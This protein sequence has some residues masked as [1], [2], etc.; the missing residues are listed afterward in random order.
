MRRYLTCFL[1][2]APCLFATAPYHGWCEQGGA[3]VLTQGLNSSTLVQQSFPNFSQSG[4]GPSVTV[5]FTG[6]TNKASLSSDSMGTVL[7]N[8]FPCSATGEYQFWA[9]TAAYDIVISG[10]G[11]LTYTISTSVTDGCP[12]NSACDANFSSLATACA[13]VG[14]GTL[15]VTFTWPSLPTGSY[16]CVMDFLSKNGTIQP[17]SGQTVTLNNCPIAGPYT[18]FDI[19]AGGTVVVPTTCPAYPEWW[20]ATG[21]GTTDDYTPT[22]AALTGATDITFSKTYLV[23]TS[24]KTVNTHP[25]L[26]GIGT[27]KAKSSGFTGTSL[28]T[29]NN[30]SAQISGITFDGNS[31]TINTFTLF[32]G[33]NSVIQGI[34]V[35][36]A[37]ANGMVFSSD[38]GSGGDCAMNA[39]NNNLIT[40]T[41]IQV[42]NNGSAGT[43]SG[44]ATSSAGTANNDVTCINCSMT[45]NGNDGLY[46]LNATGWNVIGGAANANYNYGIETSGGSGH[47]FNN[48]TTITNARQGGGS[49]L[50]ASNKDVSNGSLWINPDLTATS[51]YTNG[52][53]CYV[54]MNGGSTAL[55]F[56]AAT[57]V[58]PVLFTPLDIFHMKS[59]TGGTFDLDKNGNATASQYVKGSLLTQG[60]PATLSNAAG[61][62]LSTAQMLNAVLLRSGAAGVTDTTPTAAALVAAL[63]GV[64]AGQSYIWTIRN[65]NSG[66]LTLAAGSGVTLASGNTNTTSTVNAHYWLV[67]FTNVTPSSEAVTIYSLGSSAF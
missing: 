21:D 4:T 57:P 9:T 3:T 50:F 63:P 55:G 30:V 51:C 31:S 14:N 38:S 61:Q 33:Q 10:S 8:P 32:C 66:T 39:G 27:I 49:Q 19:S 54:Y 42:I 56:G 60:A 24:V 20:G 52:N 6:T 1:L 45:G 11:L 16:A 67:Q 65:A 64:V 47:T 36:G 41:G 59:G 12:T 43:G 25:I 62:T 18:I 28:F 7:S 46:L 23:G 13:S 15:Y 44:I 5:Y 22:Q 34:I 48:V 2:F 40:M 26:H 37:T 35:K 29:L 58:N 17:A 53:T